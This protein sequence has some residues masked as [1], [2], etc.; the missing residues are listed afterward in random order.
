MPHSARRLGEDD[1]PLVYPADHEVKV[2]SASGHLAHEGRNYHVGD[3]FA[4]K[5]VGLWL[6]PAGRTELRFANVQLGHL[7]FNAERGRFQSAYFAPLRPV[8]IPNR[9]PPAAGEGCG[10]GVWGQGA[11]ALWLGKGPVLRSGTAPSSTSF[12]S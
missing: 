3:A 2:V 10:M 9:P 5:R 1:K 4:G 6:N 7:A 8:P 12:T 11:S